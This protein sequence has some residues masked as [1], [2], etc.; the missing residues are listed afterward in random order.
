VSHHR[1]ELSYF[2]RSIVTEVAE[3]D[4][5]FARH[6]V[7]VHTTPVTSSSH[8]FRLL[9]DGGCDLALTSPDNVAAYRGSDRN[10]LA[11]QLDVRILVAV[12]GGLGL[13]VMAQPSIRDLGELRG[14][15]IGVDVPQSGFALALFGL[16]AAAGLEVGDYEVATLGSTPQRRAALLAGGCAATLLNAGH[17]IAA[18]LAGCRRLAQ[19]TDRYQPYLGAVLASTGAWLEDHEA[20][21]RRFV[22]A[23]TE[24]VRRVLDPSHKAAM[25]AVTE[26]VLEL[27]G[28]AAERFYRVLTSE[29]HG[30]VADGA[31]DPAA[32][33]TVLDLRAQQGGPPPAGAGLVDHRLLAP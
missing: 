20:D 4:G 11:Q 10:P 24:A 25:I 33:Q 32:L 14:R 7:D 15:V 9:R 3:R 22:A 13:S 5:I 23:W 31:V 30:L 12:D 19:V 21:G 27:S 18:E 16:L 26:A 1:L 8:Q 6:G 28:P 2:S 29:R 17:D